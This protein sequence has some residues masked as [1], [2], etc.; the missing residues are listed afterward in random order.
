MR[1]Q[2]LVIRLPKRRVGLA[3]SRLPIGEERD[4]APIEGVLQHLHPEKVEDRA[5]RRQREVGLL[6]VIPG[7]GRRPVAAAPQGVVVAECGLPHRRPLLRR[8]DPRAG[9]GVATA[10]PPGKQ[11]RGGGT[12]AGAPACGPRGGQGARPVG[13]RRALHVEREE[14]PPL[15]RERFP[16]R[17]DRGLAKTVGVART[18]RR[19]WEGGR[20]DDAGPRPVHTDDAPRPLRYLHLREWPHPDRHH[21]VQGKLRLALVVREN[22]EGARRFK[23]ARNLVTA[24]LRGGPLEVLRKLPVVVDLG[25]DAGDVVAQISPPHGEDELLVEEIDGAL[26]A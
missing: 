16:G 8:E 12:L 11:A 14:P 10:G 4:V 24:L 13:R 17:V 21:N 26:L 25:F 19:S 22:L 3:G 15:H 7:R 9:G 18:R 2:P 1:H 20:V 6:Q 23:R 5:L